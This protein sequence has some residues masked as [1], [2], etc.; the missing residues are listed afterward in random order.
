MASK[1][2]KFVHVC[3]VWVSA[4]FNMSVH[5]IY[6]EYHFGLTLLITAG[7]QCIC[8]SSRADGES[9]S[10]TFCITVWLINQACAPIYSGSGTA[11][12]MGIWMLHPRIMLSGKYR[13]QLSSL[14]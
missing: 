3:I 7:M 6:Y 13:T 5:V 1:V 10:L 12:D 8:Y 9:R 4:S 11:F 14:I 2:V